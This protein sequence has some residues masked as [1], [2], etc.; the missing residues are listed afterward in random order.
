MGLE[1]E[2]INGQTPLDEDEKEGL[3]IPTVTTRGDLD[4]FEQLNIEKAH[5]WILTRRFSLE[6][7]LTEEFVKELHS[8]MFGDVWSWAGIFRNSNKNIGSDKFMIG[9]DLRHLLDDTKFWIENATFGEDE[10]ALRFSHRIVSIHCFPNGN[11]R[12]SRLI[13][14]IFIEKVFGRRPFTWGGKS[15]TETSELR[16][17]YIDALREADEGNFSKLLKFTRI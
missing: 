5:E 3:L 1:L 4:E 14:D 10:I 6:R 11:G 13:G 12:H 17:K 7:V 15:L 9:I 8:Q 2:Y 16:T